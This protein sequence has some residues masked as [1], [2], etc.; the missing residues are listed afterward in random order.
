MWLVF[1]I[2]KKLKVSFDHC[3]NLY[4]AVIRHGPCERWTKDMIKE[5]LYKIINFE[6]D[7]TKEQ[8]TDLKPA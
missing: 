1:A 8:K 2:S 6:V 5:K 7:V 4:I 3:G